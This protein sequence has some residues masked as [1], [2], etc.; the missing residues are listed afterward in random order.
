MVPIEEE[1][2]ANVEALEKSL[3]SKC[4][5]LKPILQS[6]KGFSWHVEKRR[7]SNDS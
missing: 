2:K 7:F 5:T 1:N 6:L 4:W 3:E